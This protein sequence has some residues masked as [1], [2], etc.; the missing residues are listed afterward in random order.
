MLAGCDFPLVRDRFWSTG[1]DTA[2]GT[3]CSS[4]P[5]SPLKS[6]AIGRPG[7]RVLDL[8]T[9]PRV[10]SP[11]T[12]LRARKDKLAYFERQCS[13]VGHG[14]FVGAECV[15][16]NRES[17]RE[18]GITHVI[19]CVG[20]LYPAYFSPELEY[21]T[22]YLQDTP[23]EDITCILYDVFDFIQAAVGHGADPA[24]RVL[25]H[26]SQGVSRSVSLTIAYLMWREGRPYE[27]V[28]ASVKA[29]RGIANPNIGFVCQ[30]L[31]WQKR[32]TTGPGAERLYRLAPQSPAAPQYLVPRSAKILGSAGLD[33]RGSFVL[34]TSTALFLWLG[35]ACPE[36]FAAA[37]TTFAAQLERYEAA[38]A[39]AL[40]QRDGKES[41]E[42]WT[43]LKAMLSS[44]TGEDGPEA[45]GS[46]RAAAVCEIPAYD[47]DYE[48]GGCGG[49]QTKVLL[50]G[51]TPYF[52]PAVYGPEQTLS[53]SPA[54]LKHCLHQQSCR[55]CPGGDA[56]NQASSL[57]SPWT[58]HLSSQVPCSH[59]CFLAQASL[60]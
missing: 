56:Y 23:A 20:F 7:L 35:K 18:A 5:S 29:A 41:E 58:A 52:H 4:A 8:G 48:V 34:H 17:L 47:K 19:N 59:I 60:P 3:S 16:R 49:D 27:E 39:P 42:F 12:E 57:R 9:L 46:W 1:E 26:C 51:C 30:L 40:L 22:L 14:L 43:A 37:A 10:E 50:R 13:P 6:T 54:C 45:S 28:F 31:Q 21:R 25:L 15:A 32:R 38:P 36:G 2:P 53:P 55:A 24:G 44:S 33:P 11:P